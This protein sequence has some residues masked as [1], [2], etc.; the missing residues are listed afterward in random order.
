[1]TIVMMSTISIRL[2]I[3]DIIRQ[4]YRHPIR[5][6][7][8]LLYNVLSAATLIVTFT[9]VTWNHIHIRIPKIIARSNYYSSKKYL[10]SIF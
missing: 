1:M 5:D 2:P 6:K 4:V 7:L 10:I 9:S 8:H 3:Q